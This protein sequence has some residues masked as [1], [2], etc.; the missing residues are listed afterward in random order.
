MRP[1]RAAVRKISGSRLRASNPAEADVAH[2]R[3]IDDAAGQAKI[4]TAFFSQPPKP[5][6]G[7]G[8][9]IR[10]HGFVRLLKPMDTTGNEARM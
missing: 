3:G 6:I 7:S 10:L 5:C 1:G 8:R 4:A 9:R 2:A